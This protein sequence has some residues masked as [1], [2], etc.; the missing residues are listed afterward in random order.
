MY[1]STDEVVHDGEKEDQSE[2][3]AVS[4]ETVSENAVNACVDVGPVFY[5]LLHVD[6]GVNHFWGPTWNV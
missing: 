4:V 5:I 2:R 3:V 6:F 1:E